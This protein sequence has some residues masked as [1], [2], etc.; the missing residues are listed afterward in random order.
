MPLGELIHDGPPT[1]EQISLYLPVTGQLDEKAAAG[2]RYK[3]ADGKDWLVAHPLH[4]I[5]PLHAAG[6]TP[7]DAFAGVIT[8]LEPGTAYEVEVTVK[9]G[10]ATTTRKLSAATRPIPPKAGPPTKTIPAGATSAQIQSV[11]DQAVPGDVIQF[12][13]S[14]YAVDKLQSRKGARKKSL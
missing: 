11:F 2:V 4:R 9:L 12:A 13:N 10:D 7:P 8:G 14:T 6:K 5:R 1:P 3:R